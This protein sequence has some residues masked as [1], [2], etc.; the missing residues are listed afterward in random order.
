MTRTNEIYGIKQN[1]IQNAQ[2]GILVQTEKIP[3]ASRRIDISGYQILETDIVMLSPDQSKFVSV[4]V[5]IKFMKNIED[6]VQNLFPKTQMEV[7]QNFRNFQFLEDFT[8]EKYRGSLL[9]IRFG[10]ISIDN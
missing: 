3:T 2:R 8:N 1:S 10:N 4:P 9:A 7:T 6:T 5:K